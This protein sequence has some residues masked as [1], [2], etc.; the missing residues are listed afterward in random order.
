MMAQR[1]STRLKRLKVGR[2]IFNGK[3]SV[4]SCKVSD[5]S[6]EGIRIKIGEPYRVPDIFQIE[7]YGTEPRAA[8][9]VWI[10][11]GELGAAFT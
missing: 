10:G 8:R 4:L 9:K 2:V 6:D 5:I 7:M 11:S 1:K 3:Q